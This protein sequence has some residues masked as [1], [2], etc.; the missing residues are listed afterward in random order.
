MHELRGVTQKTPWLAGLSVLCSVALWAQG[1]P[2]G[3]PADEMHVRSAAYTPPPAG[4]QLRAQADLVLARVVVH[5]RQGRLVS[6]LQQSDFQLLDNG[7]PQNI[8][9][10]AVEGGPAGAAVAPRETAI[11]A[12]ATPQSGAGPPRR[13]VALFF[14]DRNMPLGDLVAAR[15]ATED[16]ISGGLN[17]GDRFAVFTSSGTVS[18][19]FT[20]D[21]RLVLEKLSALRSHWQRI[22][23]P[24]EC[25]R[26]GPHQ[27]HLIARMN[28]RAALELAVEQLQVQCGQ[29][30]RQGGRS[31]NAQILV[32]MVRR[33]SEQTLARAQ[34][35]GHAALGPL[36]DVI[37]HLATMPGQRSLLLASSGFWS[38]TL[39]AQQDKLIDQALRAGIVIHSLDAKGL[40]PTASTSD[41][42]DGPPIVLL[43]RPDLQRYADRLINE[44]RDVLTD[45]LA[46]L[47]QGTGGRFFH[48]S[49]DLARGV[50]ELAGSADVS[51]L[52]G[53]TPLGM[54][55]DG[56]FHRLSV[57]LARKGAYDVDARKGYFAPTRKE[58]AERSA[59]DFDA[60]VTGN[61]ELAEIQ[62][63]VSSETQK[64]P[65]GNGLL[66]VVARVYLRGLPF[67]RRDDRH[68]QTLRTVTALLD[69]DGK[70]L[71]GRES[72][73]VLSLRDAT[74][75]RLIVE[76]LEL[77]LSVR[78]PVGRYILRQVVLEAL[79]GKTAAVSRSVE[80]Q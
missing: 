67:Q 61:H 30:S 72:V 68:F 59:P 18:Q 56:S 26:I 54:K 74:L 5:D 48:N 31:F 7:K 2:P 36:R 63:E 51:Y 15:K 53:F 33:Q 71:H 19:E 49:N 78:V 41:P 9:Y 50:A 28:D 37:G 12:G 46:T 4:T 45:P 43:R 69:K 79:E 42:G 16:F 35:L 8:A 38:A 40:V 11:Q 62:L 52:L 60:V 23:D 6:G 77:R 57:K 29:D 65:S 25:P 73:M 58:V 66:S 75:Q 70:F 76:G 39:Q 14:D 13:Y 32:P 64:L 22:T 17:R 24:M 80:I 21:P 3:I 34:Q 27:A 44:Q 20:A 55:P 1:T 47:A 10:F